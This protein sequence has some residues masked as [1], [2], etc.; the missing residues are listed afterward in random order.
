M[1]FPEHFLW[2]GSISAAQV[3]GG[4]NEGGKSPVQIDYAGPDAGIGHRPV[5]YRA[6][7]G[8]RG[9]MRQFDRLPEGAR[10]EL[11]DDVSYTNHDA[12][13]F[14][15]HWREDLALFAEMGLTTFNTT[16]SW[17]RIYPQGVAGGVNREGVEFYRQVFTEA[18]RL[19]MDPVI[20]LYKYDEPIYFEETY[21]GWDNRA[22]I[23][24]FVAFAR[25]C[26]TEYRGLIDKWVTFNEINV[27]MMFD[28][29][30]PRRIVETHNQMVASSLAVQAAHEIDPELRVGCMI[31]G[32]CSYPYTCDPADALANQQA[33]QERFFYCADTMVRGRY[34]SWARRVQAKHGAADFT[35]SDEDAAVLAV[36][37]S[38]FMAFSYYS[39]AVVTTH[40][41][42]DDEV[43]GNLSTSVKNP[44]V[45]ASAWGWQMDPTGFRYFLNVM[46]DRYDVP[47]FDVENGLGAV[48][49][50]VI[51]DGE[52][53]IHDTYRI[54]YLRDHIANLKAAIEEDGINIF[55]YTTWG[56]IDL[57]AFTTGQIKKRYGFI[58]VDRH[59]D[60]TG[61]FARHRKDSFFWYQRVIAT[62][63]ET[64]G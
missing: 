38:D 34:P 52:L 18:R 32:Q 3:E 21:G 60:G 35:C 62:N 50:P 8:A 57:V 17:A 14:Y 46:N 23:D 61:D 59:D 45:K 54:D 44:Y 12:T 15:H 20:T 7:D 30:N 58:Y 41:L 29:E 19:G 43:A 22:M 11:F 5:Y 49:E 36:G 24:E 28:P 37:K 42:T 25:T 26:F 31:A 16:V 47:L 56:P 2:G 9:V 1:S 55:G 10:Y 64:L 33:M 48:D 27:L 4:W 13:D 53:R 63:G 6:A 39:S 51:E 40:E